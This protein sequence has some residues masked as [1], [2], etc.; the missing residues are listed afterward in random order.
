MRRLAIGIG[1]L[2]TLAMPASSGTPQD[3]A[4]VIDKALKALGGEQKLQDAK[5]FLWKVSA[6]LNMAGLEGEFNH[7]HLQP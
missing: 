4:Q 6:K 7:E 2:L 3:A 1:L 5:A